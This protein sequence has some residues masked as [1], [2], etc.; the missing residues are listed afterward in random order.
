MIEAQGLTKRFGRLTAVDAVNLDIGADQV[1]GFLGHNGAG[2]TTTLRMI[3]GYLMPSAGFVRVNGVDVVGDPVR[4][5]GQLGYLPESVPLYTEMRVREYLHFRAKLYGLPRAGRGPAIDLAVRRCRLDDVV[6]RPIHQLSKGY[7][8]RVGLAATLLHDPP[9]LILDEPTIGL[10]PAQILDI[11]QLIRDLGAHH[12]IVLSTHILP[13]VEAICDRVVMIARGRI[14]ADGTIDELIEQ[15]SPTATYIVETNHPQ[16]EQLLGH[17]RGVVTARTLEVEDAWR[18]LEVRS[19]AGA[20]DLREAL[21]AAL[22]NDAGWLVRGLER[23]RPSLEQMFIEMQ[24]SSMHQDSNAS[25]DHTQGE[26]SAAAL[27]AVT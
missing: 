19:E 7:R 8:Q 11:R 27:E 23:R 13:E 26:S 15:M 12:T 10:D 5:R 4:A 20:G 2:K 24:S 6:R 18:R 3:A 9:V 25:T 14:R 21:A 22:R 16:A 1:V 17:V